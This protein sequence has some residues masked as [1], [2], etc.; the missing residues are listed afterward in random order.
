MKKILS[1][2]IVGMCLSMAS[3]SN[4]QLFRWGIKGGLSSSN[5]KNFDNLSGVTDTKSYSGWQ[6]GVFLG[7]K[8]TMVAVDADIL[9]TVQGVKFE[10][11]AVSDLLTLENAYINIPV[12]GKFFII[13]K[14][15][16]QAGLQYGILVSSV[17]EGDKNYLGT[18]VKDEFSGGET[19][20]VFGIGAELSKFMAE[21]RY[22]LGVSDI[23]AS[24]L[25]A[26]KLSSGVLMFNIGFRLK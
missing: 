5:I 17:I 25:S 20:I 21:V 4:A 6:A 22:N 26:E 10:D 12:V 19:S 3:E 1:L 9:Y 8:F 11:P 7:A 2:L 13:P 23:N 14:I 16:L 18:P 24:S 15:N